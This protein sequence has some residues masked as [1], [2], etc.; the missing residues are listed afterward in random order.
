[1]PLRLLSVT[2]ILATCASLTRA[3]PAAPATPASQPAESAA[4]SVDPSTPKGALRA[5]A[6]AARMA[7]FETLKRVS[8]TDTDN[9]LENSLLAAANNYQKSVGDLA[10]AVRDKFG[11]AAARPFLRQRGAP[12]GAFL[13]LI[14][15][16]LDEYD[17]DVSGETARL[18]DHHDAKTETNI[19]LVREDGVWKVA[20]TGLAAQWG[21]EVVTQR[22]EMIRERTGIVSG[23]VEDVAADKYENAEAVKTALGE[24]FRR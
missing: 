10:S 9:E 5:F 22:V 15:V 11:D 17:V 18:V 3:Q 8:K 14:E 4:Q 2:L 23:F 6:K 7:D 12:L 24:A 21:K 19:K 1:M 13:Q 16:N 20:S